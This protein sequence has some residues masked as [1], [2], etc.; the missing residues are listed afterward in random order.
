MT[1]ILV[2]WLVTTPAEL[3]KLYK[4]SKILKHTYINFRRVGFL[5]SVFTVAIYVCHSVYPHHIEHVAFREQITDFQTNFDNIQ[6]F[7]QF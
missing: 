1:H 6:N 4:I 7:G 5:R 3:G 2:S